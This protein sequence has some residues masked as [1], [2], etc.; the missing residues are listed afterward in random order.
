MINRSV[1][2][3]LE[4]QLSDAKEMVERGIA[5]RKLASNREF[6]KLVLDGFC[7]EDCARFAAQSGDPALDP[8]QRADAIAMAQA[9]G[10]LKRFL[11]ATIQMGETAAREI[12]DIEQ[13]LE[14]ARVESEQN[15]SF[16][17]DTVN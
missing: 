12:G 7:K 9:G 10:H 4:G 5:A 17:E 11:S 14:E 16:E 13:E 15:N 6:R 1:V 3:G 2:E 8:Q